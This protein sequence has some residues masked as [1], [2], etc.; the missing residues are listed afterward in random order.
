LGGPYY[1]GVY[2]AQE[3]LQEVGRVTIAGARLEV[4][5]GALWWQLDKG[6]VDEITARKNSISRQ[7]ANVR[8]LARIRLRGDLQARVQEAAAE[9]ESASDLRNN[10][11]H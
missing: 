3:L 7:V 10:V 6:S 4:Q 9:A 5:M 11:V 2:P 8:R 1:A